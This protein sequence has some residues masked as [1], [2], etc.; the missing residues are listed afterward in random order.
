MDKSREIIIVKKKKGHGHGHHGGAWKVAFADFM[1]AMFAMFL[2]LWLVNQSSDVKAAV[3]GYFQD[4]L[5]SSREAGA[6]VIPGQGGQVAPPSATAP[7]V[8]TQIRRMELEK[9]AEEI[10]AALAERPEFEGLRDF[11]EI[12]LTDEGLRVELREDSAGVFFAV[13]G[14]EPTPQAAA[15]LQ[16]LG[17]EF[18]GLPNGVMI[19]GYTDGRPYSTPNGYTNWEL[20]ADRGNAAR[21][22][23]VRGGLAPLQVQGVRGHADKDL[24]YPDDPLNGANRRVTITLL[25]RR[26][27]EAD[28]AAVLG[29][30]TPVDSTATPDSAAPGGT[31]AAGARPAGAETP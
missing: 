2:V 7:L 10:R 11:I 9:K 3:A 18:G 31:A 13:G 30:R 29:G 15:F 8:L 1:T 12:T 20:S 23:L 21:R 19:D 14:A 25:L 6:S 27:N 24:R 17:A 22:L 26:V 4:P 28:V 5:G 16:L